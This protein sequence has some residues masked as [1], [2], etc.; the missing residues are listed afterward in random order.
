MIRFFELM[1][2]FLL[3]NF[4]FLWELIKFQWNYFIE[5]FFEFLN[6]FI[7]VYLNL[8]NTCSVLC[9][10][11][12]LFFLLLTCKRLINF[13]AINFFKSFLDSA[14]DVFYFWHLSVFFLLIFIFRGILM[15]IQIVEYF[16]SHVQISFLFFLD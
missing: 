5:F 14:N 6:D 2:N 10:S 9:L 3:K 4:E 11:Q 12:F 8:L 1:I 7:L 16:L 13:L 15:R